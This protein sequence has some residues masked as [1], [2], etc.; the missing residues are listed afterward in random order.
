M[1]WW[2][3]NLHTH[4]DASDGDSPAR[5]VVRW[6]DDHGYHFLVIS[7]HN[8]RLPTED[9]QAALRAEG[10][11]ILLV[12]GEELS[13]W[14]QGP[15]RTHALHVNGIDTRSTLG[16]AGGDS[17]VEVLQALIDRVLEDGGLP[18]LNHPNF[19][20]SVSAEDIAALSGLAHFEVFNGHPLAFSFGDDHLV[21][22]EAV[23]DLLLMRGRRLYGIAVDDAHHFRSWGQQFSNPG[24]G[25]VVVDAARLEVA[26]VVAALRAGRFYASTGPEISR[27]E[28]SHG[29]LEVEATAEGNFE[30][31]AAGGVVASH[32]GRQGRQSLPDHGYLRCR[33]STDRGAAWTQPVFVPA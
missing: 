17:I 18:S 6:Y 32:Q 28:T 24:R 5:D 26:E 30:F 8:L 25:W 19:W 23:W 29:D 33:F 31:F 11:H 4:T 9:L 27:I 20:E 15:S 16:A 12:P 2:K 13:S 1:T 10:R 22:M 3:G 21:P 14:W 7:D